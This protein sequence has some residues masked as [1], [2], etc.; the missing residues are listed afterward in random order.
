MNKLAEALK[1]PKNLVSWGLAIG[2]IV[3]SAVLSVALYMANREHREISYQSEVT[4]IVD[5]GAPKSGIQVL[6]NEGERVRGSV[7]VAVVTIWNSGDL[8]IDPDV[9]RKPVTITASPCVQLLDYSIIEE[10]FPEILTGSLTGA[11]GPSRDGKS[12]A[13]GWK[14]F[15]PGF[16]IKARIACAGAEPPTVEVGGHVVGIEA[17][18]RVG[19]ESGDDEQW[20]LLVVATALSLV[21]AVLSLGVARGAMYSV[22]RSS[23]TLVEHRIAKLR[24]DSLVRALSS[25]ESPGDPEKFFREALLEQLEAEELQGEPRE[26][27]ER[28][29]D[30]Y[31]PLVAVVVLA[32]L[33]AA[34]V[35]VLSIYFG[36]TP[37]PPI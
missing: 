1:Q 36:T 28:S 16:A 13:L 25:P 6:T 29:L 5:G 19:E 8:V 37:G 22:T 21:I 4:R 31:R 11:T 24:Q 15:D 2:G 10:T 9:V 18:R 17:F 32:V 33:L 20:R 30:R 12:V 3:L 23:E 34:A 27:R 35:Y 14:H 7:Y 26:A